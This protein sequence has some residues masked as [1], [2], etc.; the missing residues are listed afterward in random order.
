VSVTVAGTAVVVRFNGPK[1]AGAA[2][3]V[4]AAAAA[5]ATG[6]PA[7]VVLVVTAA[8]ALAGLWALTSLAATW[9][10]YDH[11]RVYD[12]VPTGLGAVG[13]WASVHSGFDDA[14]DH[15]VAAFG[16]HPAAVV[17]LDTPARSSL[18]RA[19]AVAPGG[20]ISAGT[21]ALPVRTAA[22]D[23]VFVTFAAHEVR[24]RGEQRALFAELHRVL[25]PGG[26]LVVTEHRR[27]LA[28]AVVYGPGALHFQRGAIWR[29]R[30]AG[31]GF[32]ARRDDAVTPFVHR[33]VWSR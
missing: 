24:D 32:V 33:A 14:T 11:R 8:G 9:W 22:L 20:A 18:R 7:T 5:Q 6:L 3:L 27:D 2:A 1:Y 19:R 4:A 23:T 31:A 15:L 29:A 21:A 30:A 17:E 26:R 10:V 12:R 25:A 28:N 16:R 13:R